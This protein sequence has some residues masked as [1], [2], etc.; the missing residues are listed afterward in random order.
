LFPYDVVTPQPT[1]EETTVER[2]LSLPADSVL[3]QETDGRLTLPPN[4]VAIRAVSARGRLVETQMLPRRQDGSY[5]AETFAWSADGTSA[6]LALENVGVPLPSGSFHTVDPASCAGCH[7]G[8]TVGLTVAQ[9]DR[10]GVDYGGGR[11]G[12]P[13]ATLRHLGMLAP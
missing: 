2:W 13:L 1:D 5:S 4:A 12:N 9:L 11:M 3:T 7:S 10:D 6:K 8:G